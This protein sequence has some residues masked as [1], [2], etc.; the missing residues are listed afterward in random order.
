MLTDSDRGSAGDIQ[1]QNN[2]AY[3]TSS[4]CTDSDRGSAGDIQL[5]NNP[6]F[7]ENYNSGSSFSSSLGDEMD[8]TTEVETTPSAMP[9]W[10]YST[11]ENL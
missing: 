7:E 4:V 2:P 6:A 11:L 10:V 1:L 3:E 5:Q 9:N 8:A